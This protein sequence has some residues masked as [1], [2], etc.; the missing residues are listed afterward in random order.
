MF[1]VSIITLTHTQRHNK[2]SVQSNI[3]YTVVDLKFASFV[4]H[5]RTYKSQLKYAF[6]KHGGASSTV[7]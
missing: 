1:P 5:P 7:T 4:K 2:E 6:S 3:I